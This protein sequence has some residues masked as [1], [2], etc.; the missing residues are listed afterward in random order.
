MSGFLFEDGKPLVQLRT[1]FSA[2]CHTVMSEKLQLLYGDSVNVKIIRPCK[3]DA[4]VKL[5]FEK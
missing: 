2:S 1:V 4:H 3:V 5:S